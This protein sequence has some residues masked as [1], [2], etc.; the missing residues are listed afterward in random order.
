MK[1]IATKEIRH[2]VAYPL[3]KQSS[4]QPDVI[5]IEGDDFQEQADRLVE[6]YEAVRI[7]TPAEG[8]KTVRSLAVSDAIEIMNEIERV[9][10]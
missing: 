6:N 1:V 5:S 8:G 2:V 3:Q 9:R 4:H 10:N 7:D